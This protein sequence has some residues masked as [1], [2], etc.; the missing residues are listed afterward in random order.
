MIL[1][2]SILALVPVLLLSF[3]CGAPHR[4]PEHVSPVVQASPSSQGAV[5]SALTHPVAESH[6]SSVQTLP[7]SQSSA[8]PAAQTPA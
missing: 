6:E 3:G 8:A 2:L 1:R 7:S 5:L 4:P